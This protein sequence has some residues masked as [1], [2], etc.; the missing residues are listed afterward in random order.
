MV[1]VCVYVL[2][3][4]VCFTQILND[5]SFK[6]LPAKEPKIITLLLN[7]EKLSHCLN[8]FLMATR[9]DNSKICYRFSS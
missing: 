6:S 2:F 8:D 9:D 3:I 4:F 5:K 1:F 7:I